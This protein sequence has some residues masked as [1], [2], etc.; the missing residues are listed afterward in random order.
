MKI[1]TIV[2]NKVVFQKA[3]IIIYKILDYDGINE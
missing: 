3:Q 1:I 2:I